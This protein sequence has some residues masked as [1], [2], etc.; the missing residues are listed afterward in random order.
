MEPLNG[1]QDL[2]D[3]RSFSPEQDQDQSTDINADSPWTFELRPAEKI[4]TVYVEFKSKVVV[5]GF[6]LQGSGQTLKELQFILL[7]KYEADEE[8]VK[9]KDE[10]LVAELTNQR[11]ESV[12][13]LSPLNGLVAL[14]LQLESVDNEDSGTGSLRFDVL[15]CKE[16][17]SII[18][19]RIVFNHQSLQRRSEGDFPFCTKKCKLCFYNIY[20]LRGN[21]KKRQNIIHVDFENMFVSIS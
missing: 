14:G 8:F 11:I 18:L 3:E 21:L 1:L 2:E 16:G 20:N 19:N 13:L 9:L 5:Q 7:A 6:K 15:G 12:V 10:K 4:P 17:K